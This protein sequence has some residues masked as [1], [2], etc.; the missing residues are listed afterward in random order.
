M[1]TIAEKRPRRKASELIAPAISSALIYELWD[2]KQ[3]YYKDYRAV[4][5]G[6]KTIEE[7]VSCSD[8]QGVL[9]SLIHGHLFGIINRKKYLLATNEIGIH[10]A[11]NNNLAND[12][13]IYDKESVGKLKG[14][15]FDVPPK[16]VIEVDIKA[17]AAEFDN[18]SDGYLMEKARKL[19]DFGVE[20]VLWIITNAQKT[21]VINK[22]DPT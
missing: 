7:V 21:Y 13:V 11:L 5:T 12:V 1:T 14:K 3:V 2:G 22:N 9:V 8:L 15:L 19:L 4:M 16:V 6:K 17:D 20:G 18:G 10:L